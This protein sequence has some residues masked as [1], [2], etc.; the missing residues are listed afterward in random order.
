MAH[1]MLGSVAEAVVRTARCPV[2][3]VRDPVSRK[4]VR[5]EREAMQMAD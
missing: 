2:L 4:R 1:L 3:T 5:G